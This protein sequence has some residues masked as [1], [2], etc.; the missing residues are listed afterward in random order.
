[1]RRMLLHRELSSACSRQPG[2]WCY[3][4][5]HA[6]RPRP[7]NRRPRRPRPQYRPRRRRDSI[8]CT[9][10]AFPPVDILGEMYVDG[11]IRW[12]LPLQT[13]LDFDPDL[14]VAVNTSLAG[15]QPAGTFRWA[16]YDQDRGAGRARPRAV[17]DTRRPLAGSEATSYGPK[18]KALDGHAAARGA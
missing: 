2:K 3:S 10:C 9:P 5:H 11:G 17:G 14:V 13:A 8:L 12:Q 4:I 1:M 15:V 6:G 16:E 18:A 7:R